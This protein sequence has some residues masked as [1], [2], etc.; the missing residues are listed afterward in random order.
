[1]LAIL[2]LY[3]I[4]SLDIADDFH[5]PPLFPRSKLNAKPILIIPSILTCPIYEL[6]RK[7]SDS[8]LNLKRIICNK[9]KQSQI[10]ANLSKLKSPSSE[11]D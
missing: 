4:I 6:I 2:C 8:S 10:Y 5:W 3:E 11:T 9:T 1:M 7:R